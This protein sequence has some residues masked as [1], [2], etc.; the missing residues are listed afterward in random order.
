M[1]ERSKGLN[2]EGI[3]PQATTAESSSPGLPVPYE[4]EVQASVPK[5]V[6]GALTALVREPS[7]AAAL[8]RRFGSD[9]VKVSIEGKKKGPPEM[10]SR[11]GTVTL[12]VSP[13]AGLLKK[14]SQQIREQ[15]PGQG[16][17]RVGYEPRAREATRAAVETML[18]AVLAW[19][20]RDFQ[21]PPPSELTPFLTKRPAVSAHIRP[22]LLD[23]ST[24]LSPLTEL[25]SFAADDQIK[26]ELKSI[27]SN[28]AGEAAR[29]FF[30]LRDEK[31]LIRME[32]VP[33]HA[34]AVA[35]YGAASIVR[36]LGGG[37][38]ADMQGF[39]I[40]VHKVT[41]LIE[42]QFTKNVAKAIEVSNR[43]VLENFVS[44]ASLLLETWKMRGVLPLYAHSGIL[45]GEMGLSDQRFVLG[46]HTY[47][48]RV[49]QFLAT[50]DELASSALPET[51]DIEGEIFQ[52]LSALRQAL[53]VP[54]D[55]DLRPWRDDLNTFGS[56]LIALALSDH[57]PHATWFR[58]AYHGLLRPREDGSD[59]SPEFILG[60]IKEMCVWARDE[61]DPR[62]RPE[63]HAEDEL[64]S[65]VAQSTLFQSICR[66]MDRFMTTDETKS[67]NE[68]QNLLRS[69]EKQ[70]ELF[71][72][73]LPAHP[74]QEV[75]E[76]MTLL[77]RFHEACRRVARSSAADSLENP[78]EHLRNAKDIAHEVIL[79]IKRLSP[80]TLTT[81]TPDVMQCISEI[82]KVAQQ[83][84]QN[85]LVGES[86]TLAD[87][88]LTLFDL[89]DTEAGEVRLRYREVVES[90][91]NVLVSVCQQV[92]EESR[93]SSSSLSSSREDVLVLLS[94]VETQFTAWKIV[95][96]GTLS[97]SR[98]H[99]EQ[100]YRRA[101]KAASSYRGS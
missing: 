59:D 22:S 100:L 35:R 38:I 80:T 57:S 18:Q 63:I 96:G 71:S 33:Q 77:A 54:A 26:R 94:E 55:G 5:S 30:A 88:A 24:I 56:F 25:H 28:A 82:E 19:A 76:F 8:I 64:L 83:L 51:T 29:S 53:S 1:I 31:G 61:Q 20:T 6:K 95:Q 14:F 27:A 47:R 21:A 89:I 90:G 52:R 60:M 16:D 92:C 101:L 32:I 65:V 13:D 2:S 68:T 3:E 69:L 67:P 87:S 75:V 58:E 79:L 48:T 70:A 98:Q 62:L 91:V 15:N 11:Q 74:S 40:E 49:R 7:V 4:I 41:Q 36:Y 42:E 44:S 50:H 10:V 93:N 81:H 99:V 86:L 73:I 85:G 12:S 45:M 66:T 37:S 46:L 34:D 97:A 84:G 78:L 72:T 39:V 43:L 23:C 17:T 9:V